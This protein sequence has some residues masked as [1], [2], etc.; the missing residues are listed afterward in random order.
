MDFDTA[1][2]LRIVQV[3]IVAG[4]IV[5]GAPFV[6]DYYRDPRVVGVMQVIAMSV[7]VGGLENI[8]IVKFQKDMEF[9][10]EFQ[11]FLAKRSIGTVV[12]IVLAFTLRSYWA[13]VLGT[14][15]SRA[16]GV[17]LSY[18]MHEFR[19]RL[20][21]VRWRQIWDFSQWNIVASVASYGQQRIDQFVIG[22][23]AEA[24]VLGAYSV[25]GE[26]AKMPSTELLAPLG[27]VM[28]PAFVT[29]RDNPSELL[30]IVLLSL[31]V[32]ALIGIP[33]GVGLALVAA[34][35]VP[36]LLG[37]RWLSAVPFVQ[38]L[39]IGSVASALS[40]SSNYLLLSLGKI[41]TL[42]LYHVGL[43]V[44]MAVLLFVGFPE[45]DAE[46]IAVLRL[47]VIVL[48]LL[49]IQGL[50]GAAL[51]GFGF[52]AIVI[53]TWRPLLASL[54]MSVAVLAA[55]LVLP[56]AGP[57]LLLIAK[58]GTGV[59]TYVVT[60]LVLWKLAGSPDGGET[61]LVEKFRL[62]QFLSRTGIA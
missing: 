19:P 30:R 31:S 37:D 50:A 12:T 43:L 53:Q 40:N 48:A 60:L 36:L 41:R 58:I 3:T 15:A 14:L 54:L 59:L 29:I 42:A 18:V 5:A 28:F 1:W 17:V 13:L 61:Y 2:T 8:G 46:G 7:F 47:A 38:V 22:R 55:H 49:V 16:I 39:S 24:S 27:R 32:Q 45:L 62:R 35:A 26:I 4:I 23:R 44:L 57:V 52:A 20:S 11:F 25:G 34:E 51:A 56:R 9:G 33:A 10:R 21:V 6:A